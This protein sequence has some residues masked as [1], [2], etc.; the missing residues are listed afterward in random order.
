[1]PCFSRCSPVAHACHGVI[2]RALSTALRVYALP[3]CKVAA[4]PN[5][6]EQSPNLLEGY[7]LACRFR[8]QL[9]L[10]L[11]TPN[12]LVLLLDPAPYFVAVS[13]FLLACCK[14]FH[15]NHEVGVGRKVP[16]LVACI[17]KWSFG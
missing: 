2:V 5:R 14:F 11:N 1:M 16:T 17:N 8:P 6:E 12:S 9:F 13:L 4:P 15:C 10:L 3:F 7:A